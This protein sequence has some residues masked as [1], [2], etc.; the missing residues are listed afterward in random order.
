MSKPAGKCVFCAGTGLSKGHIWPDWFR[1]VLS[2][3]AEQHLEISG[4]IR[5]F[6][7]KMKV[8]PY[9]QKLRQGHAGSRKPRNTCRTC[10]GGWMSRLEA[11]A[12]PGMTPLLLGQPAVLRTIDQRII[13]ALLCLITIRVEFADLATLAVPPEDRTWI[14]EHL[15]PPMSWRIWIARYDGSQ[16]GQHWCRH[17]GMSIVSSPDESGGSYQCNTQVTT[18]VIGQLCAHL[19]SSTALPDF[20]GYE[21]VR[22]T[23]IWPPSNF[24]IQTRLLANLS[25]DAVVSLSE[26]LVREMSP[27]PA[28]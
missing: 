17:H 21:G 11:A 24:D 7:P 12:I 13:A 18:M 6:V 25:D 10:N 1:K 14:K 23:Q 19:F 22:L 28:K 3:D 15:L 9:A 4:E 27:I 16:S 8:V 2:L 26:A 5:T 20:A